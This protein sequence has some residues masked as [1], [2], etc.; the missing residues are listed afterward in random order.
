[1]TVGDAVRT[2]LVMTVAFVDKPAG[3]T[4]HR[5]LTK[6]DREPR[7][8]RHRVEVDRPRRVAG[9]RPEPLFD[10][11][12]TVLRDVA[13]RITLLVEGPVYGS[14][15]LGVASW[16]VC[17]EMETSSSKWLRRSY[18]YSLSAIS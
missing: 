1:M 6:P 8:R 2:G 12:S 5:A 16:S 3:R 14:I 4:L 7:I 18:R 15:S 11:V 10:P 13:P 9:A 17:P